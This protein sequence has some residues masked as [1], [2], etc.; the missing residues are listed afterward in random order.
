METFLG[1]PG[2]PPA[3]GIYVHIAARRIGCSG[4]TVRRYIQQGKL[5]AERDGRR[6]WVVFPGDVDSLCNERGES[7]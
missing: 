1:Y 4:R 7:C 5:R 2:R 3:K 6:A